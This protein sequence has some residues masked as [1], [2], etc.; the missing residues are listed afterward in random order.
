MLKPVDINNYFYKDRSLTN[1]IRNVTRYKINM[2]RFLLN[3]P[4]TLLG[5]F[6]GITSFPSEITLVKNPYAF[7]F[8]V[9]NLWWRVSYLK[10][11]GAVTIGHVV[12]LSPKIEDRD[13]EHELVH[14]QQHQRMPIIHP[15]LYLFELLAK[16][17]RN[18]KYEDE[19]Y[20]IAGNVYKG[21]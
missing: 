18:N 17:Y 2:I 5:I 20:R 19:A 4:Y 7:I 1:D 6:V 9:R 12:L 15:V 16:G 14:V 3:L 8:K 13:L 10:H 21:K 11:A